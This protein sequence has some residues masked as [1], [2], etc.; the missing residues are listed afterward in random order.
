MYCAPHAHPEWIA[1]SRVQLCHPCNHLCVVLASDMLECSPC[2]YEGGADNLPKGEKETPAWPARQR[3]FAL[4]WY[5]PT[6]RPCAVVAKM[7]KR[8]A[9]VRILLALFCQRGRAGSGSGW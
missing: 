1:W 9:E 6:P 2:M 8:V 3:S 7:A 5:A 4:K